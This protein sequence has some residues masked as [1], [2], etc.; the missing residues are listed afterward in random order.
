LSLGSVLPSVSDFNL[1]YSNHF[2]YQGS[3]E[4]Y[5][6]ASSGLV[7][8]HNGQLA[9]GVFKFLIDGVDQNAVSDH[10][11]Q[12]MW[13]PITR[14]IPPGF[15]TLEWKYTKYN[16]LP[17]QPMEDLAAEIEYI[18]IK[19]V[20][21]SVRECVRC[22]KGIANEAQSRCITCSANEYHDDLVAE[23]GECVKCPGNTFSPPGSVGEYACKPRTPCT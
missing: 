16:N 12:G 15:H 7:N 13:I 1:L 19:G 18:K 11:L 14:D 21:Y 5:Y 4:F 20:S 3:V 6:R 2:L 23:G 9:N 17:G 8:T 10:L 22:H